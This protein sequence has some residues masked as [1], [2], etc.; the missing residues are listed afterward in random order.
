MNAWVWFFGG[1]NYF[2]HSLERFGAIKLAT[3]N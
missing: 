3:E 2:Q 1:K